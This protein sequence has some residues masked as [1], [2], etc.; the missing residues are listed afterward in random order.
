[1]RDLIALAPEHRRGPLQLRLDDLHAR[2]PTPQSGA[3][4]F[5]PGRS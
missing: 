4:P 2:W 5:A 1:L 3:G